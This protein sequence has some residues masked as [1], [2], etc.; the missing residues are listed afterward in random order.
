MK[1]NRKKLVI[2]SILLVLM[3][4][5]FLIGGYTYSKYLT[6]VRGRGVIDVARWDFTVNGSNSVMEN[7]DLARTCTPETLVNNRI[8]P[9]VKGSFD[10]VINAQQ[11]DTAIEYVVHFEN[12]NNKPRNLKF[13]YDNKEVSEINELEQYLTGI[14]NA[15][16]E[17]KTRTLT[18]EWYW[19]Y[20]DQMSEEQYNAIQQD[21]IIDTQDGLNLGRYSFD[22]IVTGIQVAPEPVSI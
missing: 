16:D 20:G 21:D 7:I 13:K 15:N 17:E 4:A 9:G 19:L 3:L 6:Q 22:V 8:A 1:N 18:I 2:A 10:I 12:E 11:S 14:I 5:I